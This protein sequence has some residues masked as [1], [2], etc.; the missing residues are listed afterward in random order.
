MAD[1]VADEVGQYPFEQGRIGLKRR[2]RFEVLHIDGG[3]APGRQVQRLQCGRQDLLQRGGPQAERERAG[4]QAA[5]IEQVLHQ[6]V[7]PVQGHLGGL[8]EFRAVLGGDLDLLVAQRADRGQRPCQGGSQV[9]AH[10]SEQGGAQAVGGL[11]GFDLGGGLGQPGSLD[12]RADMRGEG[13]QHASLG[14]RQRTTAQDEEGFVPG[15][16]RKGGARLATGGTSALRSRTDVGRF[17]SQFDGVHAERL[18]STFQQGRNRLVASDDA[19]RERRH[20]F[21][22]CRG[23]RGTAGEAQGP[24]RRGCHG[25]GDDG[26]DHQRQHTVRVAHG[27][28]AHWR[29]EPVVEEQGS[30]ERRDQS[31]DHPADAGH[32]HDGHEEQQRLAGEVQRAAHAV[33][34]EGEQ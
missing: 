20:G 11:D 27:E 18:P 2:Y 24:V 25:G 5:E 21:R 4:L 16:H 17:G 23:P 33:E 14:G 34:S 13:G 31:G 3:P 28:L 19:A 32:A 15:R 10:G 7:E 9:V 30:G 29:H 12:R 8:Q 22:F 26:E 1:R 6:A